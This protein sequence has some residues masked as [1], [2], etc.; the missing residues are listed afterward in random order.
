MRR[1]R[2]KKPKR[3][4]KHINYEHSNSHTGSIRSLDALMVQLGRMPKLSAFGTI[5][6]KVMGRIT[7][8]FHV[9]FLQKATEMD[10]FFGFI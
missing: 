6:R 5:T 10:C 1:L 9:I 8:K 4:L 7:L 2:Q 3:T